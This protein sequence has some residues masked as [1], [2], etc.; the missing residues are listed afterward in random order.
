VTFVFALQWTFPFHRVRDKIIEVLSAKYE[1]QI[2]DV[3]RGIIPGRVY[4][5]AVT[6]RTRVAKA[7]DVP[8][9]FYIERL[10]VDVGLLALL[11]STAEIEIDAKIGPGHITGTIELS[12]DETGIHL[13]G[14]NLPSASLP[15]KEALGLPMSGKVNFSFD[16][17]LPNKKLKTGKAGPDWTKAARRSI[18]RRA[19]RSATARRSSNRSSRT[20][21][22][23]RSPKA[24][25]S[26]ARST[27][28]R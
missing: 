2:G 7:D 11:G 21:A 3:E 4:F 26:S 6:L 20:T 24:A 17:D 28:R 9:T 15:M 23:K 1:V 22:I 14:E 27:C 18:A 10:K 12:K 8:T 25:S 16:L 19:A 13:V 5:K